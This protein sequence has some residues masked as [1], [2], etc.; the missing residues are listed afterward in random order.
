[1][2]AAALLLLFFASE[3]QTLLDEVVDVRPADFRYVQVD[4]KQP[5]VTIHYEF[6]VVSGDGLVRVVLVNQE[7]L[8]ALKQGDRDPLR[9]GA[10]QKQGSF[11][12]LISVPDEYAVVIE[13]RGPG[14]AGVR[15]R[16]SL[17]FSE[18]GRPQARYLSP[19]RR[20]AVIGI[21]ASVFLAIVFYS[22]RKLLGAVRS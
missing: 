18:R 7:G 20:W 8:E 1:M 2:S 5:P 6:H 21:S 19:E 4:L 9:S 11:S 3:Q 16:V 22:A 15:L 12:R 10:F 17:D 14:R 13:N